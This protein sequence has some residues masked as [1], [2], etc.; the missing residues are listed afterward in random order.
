MGIGSTDVSS[1]PG[2]GIAPYEEPSELGALG[3]PADADSE[4]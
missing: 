4:T 3:L 1:S 2:V